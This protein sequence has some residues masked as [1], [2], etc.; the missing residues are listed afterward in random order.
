MMETTTLLFDADIIAYKFAVAGQTNIKFDEGDPVVILENPEDVCSEVD[1]YIKHFM[2][3]LSATDYIVCLSSSS[4]SNFRKKF[5]PEYKAN[6]SN[7][8]R[9]VMLQAV[10]E[11]LELNHPT[12]IRDTLEADDVMGILSTSTKLCRCKKIIVS[13]DKDMK[14]IPGW[15]FNPRKDEQPRLISEEEADYW[16]LYQTLVG[17]TTDNY[18]GCPGIG[19][20]KA[21]RALADSC[22]WQTVVDLFVAKGLTEDDALVQARLARI[23]RAS[24]YDFKKKEPILWLPPTK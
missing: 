18:K 13:E 1:E 15:L 20:K 11:H 23:L 4:A 14:T 10:R 16:H 2:D 5:F 12:Y 17:D 19:E 24:D 3:Y 21:E 22:T 8:V 6:R 7:I 9:P